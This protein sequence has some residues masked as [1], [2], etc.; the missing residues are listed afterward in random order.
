ML[1]ARTSNWPSLVAKF[2]IGGPS[3]REQ[4]QS[5]AATVT[6]MHVPAMRL[7]ADARTTLDSMDIETSSVWRDRTGHVGRASTLAPF[8]GSGPKNIPCLLG[9]VHAYTRPGRPASPPP[10]TMPSCRC[11]PCRASSHSADVE[12]G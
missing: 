3:V 6:A 1:F 7:A 9:R 10:G 12:D 11:M 5:E 2:A 4:P 8:P